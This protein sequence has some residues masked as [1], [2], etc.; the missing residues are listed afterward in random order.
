MISFNELSARSPDDLPDEVEV[1]GLGNF[2]EGG[3][4]FSLSQGHDLDAVVAF[5]GPVAWVCP[6]E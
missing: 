6:G 5:V 2:A 4:V 3:M 1:V